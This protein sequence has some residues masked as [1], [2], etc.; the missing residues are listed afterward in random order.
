MEEE[1]WFRTCDPSFSH[2][3]RVAVAGVEN[4]FR[5]LEVC[6]SVFTE[7][8]PCGLP[9]RS[10]NLFVAVLLFFVLERCGC[11]ENLVSLH[12]FRITIVN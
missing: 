1:V 11:R 9:S 7:D 2:L 3:W 12:N 5:T 6:T 10:A 4:L 8:G